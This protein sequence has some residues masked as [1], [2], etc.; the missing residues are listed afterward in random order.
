MPFSSTGPRSK[1]RGK[2][3]LVEAARDTRKVQHVVQDVCD[4]DGGTLTARELRAVR[5]AA[6]AQLPSGRIVRRKTLFGR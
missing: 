3:A 1:S 2:V 6:R 4:G 5:M